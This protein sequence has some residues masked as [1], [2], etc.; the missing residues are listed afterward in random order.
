MEQQMKW[1]AIAGFSLIAVWIVGR[2]KTEWETADALDDQQ[3]H[4]FLDTPTRD[5]TTLDQ[6]LVVF[7]YLSYLLA[8]VTTG[9]SLLVGMLITFVKKDDWAGTIFHSH[10][11]NQIGIFIHAI[12]WYFLAGL[13]GSGIIRLAAYF[14][15]SM[16]SLTKLIPDWLLNLGI[17]GGFDVVPALFLLIVWLWLLFRI[18]KGTIRALEQRAYD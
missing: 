11:R 13:I 18:I 12:G 5:V 3:M 7:T 8:W 16:T 1:A 4:Q 9:G 6:C 17:L 15:F 14:A 2:S 10:V